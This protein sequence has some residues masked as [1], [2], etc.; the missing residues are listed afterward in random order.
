METRAN[1]VLI[2]V[3]A[4]LVVLA[5][6]GFIMWLSHMQLHKD[7]KLYDI[8]FK[9]TVSG[10]GPGADVRYNG[11]KYG[12]VRFIH[13]KPG[14]PSKVLVRIELN[15]DAPVTVD[16]VATVESLSLTGVSSINLSGTKPGGTPLVAQNGEDYPVIPSKT[17]NIENLLGGVPELV[18]NANNAIDKLNLI[19]SDDNQQAIHNILKNTEVMTQAFATSGPKVESFFTNADQAARNLNRFSTQLDSLGGDL[20]QIAQQASVLV[21]SATRVTSELE[22]IEKDNRAALADFTH[23]GLGDITRFATEARSLIRSLDRIADHLDSDPQS[24]IYG[25]GATKET[26]LK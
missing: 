20:H 2:G 14:D 5:A 11:L 6:F 1:H 22:G 17:S 3:F 19:L 26:K 12:Q 10:V 4:T 23:N 21:E 24:I 9:G 25:P 16:T 18:A 7:V 8:V 15:A 13:L